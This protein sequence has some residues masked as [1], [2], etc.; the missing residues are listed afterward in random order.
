M[1]AELKA[2]EQLSDEG[3][4]QIAQGGMNPDEVALYDLLLQR[5]HAGTLT[6]E[7]REWLTRLR[8]AAEALMLRKA[9]AYTVLQSR[10]HTLPSLEDLRASSP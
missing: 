8:E 10:G 9:H 6:P 2:I 5:H 3:L 7:G 1:Q 4:W